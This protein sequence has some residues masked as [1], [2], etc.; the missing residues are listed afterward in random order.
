METEENL[1]FVEVGFCFFSY[2]YV[3]F[4]LISAT[5]SNMRLIVIG[6]YLSTLS[7]PQHTL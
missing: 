1:G 2:R 5:L 7:Q 4:C 3:I 6:Y